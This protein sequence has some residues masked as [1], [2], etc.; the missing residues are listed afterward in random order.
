MS[1]HNCP[2]DEAP[3]LFLAGAQIPEAVRRFVEPGKRQS[4]GTRALVGGKLVGWEDQ[5]IF[6][7]KA[8]EDEDQTTNMPPTRLCTGPLS[9]R[10]RCVR[11]ETTLCL[12]EHGEE[13]MRIPYGVLFAGTS[14]CTK[15]P[16]VLSMLAVVLT[17]F[18]P[19]ANVPH[20]PI[21][22]VV[23]SASKAHCCGGSPVARE[24]TDP[25][26]TRVIYTTRDKE[27]TV[28]APSRRLVS[29]QDR[30]PLSLFEASPSQCTEGHISEQSALAVGIQRPFKDVNG[31]YHLPLPTSLR[32]DPSDPGTETNC[33]TDFNATRLCIKYPTKVAPQQKHLNVVDDALVVS[34]P[35]LQALNAAC[36]HDHASAGTCT[37]VPHSDV[38]VRVLPAHEG[39][40]M[41]KAVKYGA[42]KG[43]PMLVNVGLEFW[44]AVGGEPNYPGEIGE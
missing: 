5:V 37:V 41:D 7:F 26:Y 4:M 23:E 27:E 17:R 11:V 13:G 14:R 22:I 2:E 20:H 3:S 30:L 18:E 43:R 15:H 28:S 8:G 25:E 34:A 40:H 9:D 33:I 42:S 36:C 29:D 10:V 35:A 6:A 12:T 19:E 31:S 24:W 16:V 32:T 21:Q 1:A 44:V 38:V 39:G